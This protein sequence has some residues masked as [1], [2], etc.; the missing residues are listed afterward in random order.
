MRSSTWSQGISGG[1]SRSVVLSRHECDELVWDIVET[2]LPVLRREIERIIA[3]KSDQPET[4][5]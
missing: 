5:A 4:C 1:L 2:R 3:D